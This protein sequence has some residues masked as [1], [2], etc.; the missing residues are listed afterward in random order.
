MNH[1]KSFMIGKIQEWALLAPAFIPLVYLDLF[2]YPLVAPKAF[3]FRIV[4]TLAL[5][6]FT[7]LAYKGN[8][9]Y[10][11]R[12]K[13]WWAYIPLALLL[14]AYG[15]SA[16]GVDF[17]HSFWSVFDRSAGL[18]ALTYMV[19][20]FYLLILTIS[21]E[22]I[23]KF[24][25]LVGG[26]ASVVGLYAIVQWLGSVSGISIPGIIDTQG[27]IGATI[28][29][30]AFLAGYLG[31]T[32]FITLIVA[33]RSVRR[34]DWWRAAAFIQLVAIVLTATRGTILAL[35]AVFGM[36]LVYTAATG[37]GKIKNY[38]LVAIT[39]GLIVLAAF[40]GFRSQLQNIPFEPVQRI[41]KISADD[42]TTA[43]RLFV[44]EN[45]LS[46]GLAKPLTGYGAEHIDYVFDQFY[47]AQDIIEQW[48]D[49]SH[50]VYLDYF[51]QYGIVGLVL[52]LFFIAGLFRFAYRM[53][54]EDSF[55]GNMLLLLMGTYVLQSMF[56]FDTINTLIIL[57]P[58]FAMSFAME[59][60][61]TTHGGV[62]WGAGALSVLSIVGIYFSV[63]LPAYANI[64]LGQSYTYHVVNAE[65]Y[66]TAFS[67]GFS[68]NT[69][70]N[71]EFGY[72]AY[73]MYTD[74]QQH[75]F[76]G[77]EKGVVYKVAYDALLANTVRYPYDA[78][79]FVYFGHVLEARP[80]GAP[81]NAKEN[82]DVLHRAIELS[83]NR[84]QPYYMLANFYIAQGNATSGSLQKEFYQNAISAVETYRDR[85]PIIAEPHIVLAEL[86]RVTGDAEQS[87]VSFAEGMRLYDG[88]V[89]DARRIAGRLLA[90]NK[91]AEAQPYLETVYEQNPD[92]YIAI[93]DLAKVRFIQGD[94]QGAVELVELLQLESP[95]TLESDTV[96]IESLVNALQ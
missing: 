82:L 53:R 61:K 78:R 81:H 64:Q 19:A 59:E 40:F 33:Q 39:A 43:S 16:V 94:I 70:A 41:A 86:Y 13:S 26:V 73:A 44:W 69:F 29:N 35:I 47:N 50:N 14:V 54:K 83:P 36:A 87:E 15:T 65:K 67:E 6:A 66:A 46:Y 80:E 84:A 23:W 7:Y 95:R 74:R 45:A 55:V 57:I 37:Q 8:S 1:L 30:A 27:R 92:D 90:Q 38:A 51:L 85:A 88:E 93:F 42:A 22:F 34:A 28:G 49:R 58:L 48:F 79:T 62:V 25:T 60:Q 4:I 71:L 32:F 5:L 18:I 91:I 11:G 3:F 17:Y 96:F 52:F 89:Q 56:V 77:A 24:F 10:L 21:K 68:K 2:F 76:S 12:L 31:L 75:V 63:F 9:L 20:Y 72:Q